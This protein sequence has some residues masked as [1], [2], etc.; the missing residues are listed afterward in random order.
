MALCRSLIGRDSELSQLRAACTAARDGT[1][2]CVIVRGLAGVGKS[3]LVRELE[4]WAR[5]NGATVLRGRATAATDS[6]LRPLSEALLGVARRGY[7][8]SGAALEPFVPALGRLVPDWAT[9]DAVE[10]APVVVGEG[11]LRVLHSL[12]AIDA[13]AVLILDDLH[14]ADADTAA[15][16]EYLADH[17]A[18]EPILLIAT[19]RDGER[20]PGVD[21]CTRMLAARVGQLI[22]LSPL[23]AADT[24]EMIRACLGAETVP[25]DFVASVA[26]R[27]DGVPFLIEELLASGDR[28]VPESV[29]SSVAGRVASLPEG[30]IRLLR[31]AA[32][33]GRSFDWE[34]AARAAS[35]AS[36]AACSA[37]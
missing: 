21:S 24:D 9:V 22:A 27:S 30:G 35:I 29:R 3:R 28:V 15:V 31:V 36:R 1:G 14:W 7:R 5:A 25:D 26:R 33:M 6:P 16:V 12:A 37:S 32:L 18:T 13:P 10:L 19:V 2:S 11:V 8:P 20:G 4:V 34:V 23:D 17:V